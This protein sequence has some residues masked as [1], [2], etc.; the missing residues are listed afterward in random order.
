MH[1]LLVRVLHQIT[2]ILTPSILLT[3]RLKPVLHGAA[4][5]YGGSGGCVPLR[6]SPY[7]TWLPASLPNPPVR[8]IMA[9]RNDDPR[10]PPLPRLYSLSHASKRSFRSHSSSFEA[11]DERST[12]ISRSSDDIGGQS[13]M[14]PTQSSDSAMPP[15]R[16]PG[17]DTRRK[18]LLMYSSDLGRLCYRWSSTHAHSL[19]SKC[20]N[21][22]EGA[23]GLVYVCV[24][25][26]NICCLW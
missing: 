6:N 8:N 25:S 26:R 3:R 11:D 7:A 17:E 19:F 20:S 2:P 4:G 23:E 1:G 13:A 12:S 5:S 24:C 16:Y 18:L 9:P 15:L 14:S 10:P 22:L 21:E